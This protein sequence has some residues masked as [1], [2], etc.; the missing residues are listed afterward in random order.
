MIKATEKLY[1]IKKNACISCIQREIKHSE[2]KMVENVKWIPLL[3]RIKRRF[4]FVQEK[5]WWERERGRERER[6]G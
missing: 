6:D 4:T 3:R 1:R 2:K 5:I